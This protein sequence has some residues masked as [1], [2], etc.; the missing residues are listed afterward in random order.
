MIFLSPVVPSTP[1]DKAAESD[2]GVPW[3]FNEY[4]ELFLA[5]EGESQKPLHALAARI[6]GGESSALAWFRRLPYPHY[7]LT[8]MR[9]GKVSTG[10]NGDAT[11]M[12]LTDW[13]LFKGGF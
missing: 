10:E 5:D 13:E 6:N 12:D 11:V 4:C 7:R 2:L 3:G 8:R 1:A 9:R